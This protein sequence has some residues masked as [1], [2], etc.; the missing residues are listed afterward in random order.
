MTENAPT[1]RTAHPLRVTV[2]L[3]GL[4]LLIAGTPSCSKPSPSISRS[5]PEAS[6]SATERG[7]A[8]SRRANASATASDERPRR[9][10]APGLASNATPQDNTA[11][12]GFRDERSA[13][14]P[15]GSST[16]AGSQLKPAEN[17]STTS[18]MPVLAVDERRNA[19]QHP[20]IRRPLDTTSAIT[21][22]QA[23]SGQRNLVPGIRKLEGTHLTLYTDVPS[24][25]EVDE[26]PRVFDLA[27]EPWCQ[28][29][30]VDPKQVRSWQMTGYLMDQPERFVNAGM[31]PGDLPK[32]L[33]GYQ[34]GGELWLN[35][36]PSAYYRRHL[37]LH[38]GTHAF[39]H[40]QL[41]GTGPPW[42][43]E[44][45]AELLGTHLWKDG[46]L[47]LAY[48]PQ[49]RQELDKWGRIAMVRE[50]FAAGRGLSLEQIATYGPRAHLKNEAYGWC[51]AAAAFLDGHPDY[52]QRFRQLSGHVQESNDRFAAYF[53]KLYDQDRR[54]LDEQWQLFVVNLDYGYDLQREAIIYEPA[55]SQDGDTVTA[56]IRADRGWQSTGVQV[57]AGD[58]YV[59]RASGRYQIASQPKIWWCEPG[60]V[61]IRYHQ[62]L[63]LGMLVAA[64]SDQTQPLGGV[65]PLA[66]PEPI[67]L[68]R[69]LQ[70]SGPGT[71]F[72]RVNDAPSELSDNA[73][74]LTVTIRRLAGQAGKQLPGQSG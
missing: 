7:R 8:Q 18:G 45:M 62:H 56:T 37:L 35:E 60:G 53:Q 74:E 33:N 12:T 26:L 51:W 4:A 20:D 69:E 49:T 22:G 41:R 54:R 24:A 5:G 3:C 48:F 15:A 50:Q 6:N 25:P 68:Q 27:V 47:Q 52:A 71:M 40:W 44:G 30:H 32:F 67:G 17:I 11:Q 9:R 57:R 16:V 59:V 42:Y 55:A 65:T 72:L 31:L 61:T 14:R 23:L 10:G 73:G 13:V 43:M 39:M 63:P 2:W 70:F 46:Q 19:D 66:H 1:H 29:F 64:V 36:Q 28:Y 34:R 58:T 21:S 38:E